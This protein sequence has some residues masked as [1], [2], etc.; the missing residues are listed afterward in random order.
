MATKSKQDSA[1]E[2]AERDRVLRLFGFQP[3]QPT[4]RASWD[5]IAENDM[6]GRVAF[7]L[8][9]YRENRAEWSFTSLRDAVLL[10][11]L[12]EEDRCAYLPPDWTETQPSAEWSKAVRRLRMLR[13]TDGG[14]MAELAGSIP[15]HKLGG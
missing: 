10:G 4:P 3:H 11:D 14:S 7:A 12:S 1:A 13:A 8:W 15:S 6:R 5:K 2:E 9:N